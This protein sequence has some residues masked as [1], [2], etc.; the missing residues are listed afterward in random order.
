MKPENRTN[1]LIA[2]GFSGAVLALGAPITVM[3]VFG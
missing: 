3:L 2:L 1:L